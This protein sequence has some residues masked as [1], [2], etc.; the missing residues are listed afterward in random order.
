MKG[1]KV[2]SIPHPLGSRGKPGPWTPQG[3]EH[4]SNERAWHAIRSE[5]TDRTHLE[6][7][8]HLAI[9]GEIDRLHPR[10]KGGHG[11][12]DYPTL[13]P[14]RGH[15]FAKRRELYAH[16]KAA[17]LA[18]PEALDRP[19]GQHEGLL[20][21]VLVCGPGVTSV[22]PGDCVV[23]NGLLGR[24]MGNSLGEGVYDFIADVPYV[25]AREYE[26]E[27]DT[28]TGLPYQRRMSDVERMSGGQILAIVEES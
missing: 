14:M 2:A 4:L 22:K 24:D 16:A 11:L 6:K 13:R 28:V 3:Q 19:S 25:D 20:Y 8:A 27:R 9:L 10:G 5:Q 26:T 18:I 23:V 7:D 21:D 17:G 1:T 15:L 12:D